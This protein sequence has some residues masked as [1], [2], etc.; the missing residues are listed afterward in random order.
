[1]NPNFFE[2][3]A[4]LCLSALRKG[5]DAKVLLLGDSLVR[6][7]D[8]YIN[9]SGLSVVNDGYGGDTASNGGGR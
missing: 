1:M 8:G 9:V 4:Y 2:I 6:P 3:R 5:D 7:L